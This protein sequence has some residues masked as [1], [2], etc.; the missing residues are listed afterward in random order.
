MITQMRFDPLS[1]QMTANPDLIQSTK[2][3][4]EVQ[5]NPSQSLA[6]RNMALE[7]TGSTEQFLYVSVTRN[8]ISTK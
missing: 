8:I 6:T 1:H 3:F 2:T 7:F 5:R 4:H